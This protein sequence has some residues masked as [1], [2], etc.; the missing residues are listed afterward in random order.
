MPSTTTRL[1]AWGLLTMVLLAM[2]TLSACSSSPPEPSSTPQPTEAPEEGQT[3]TLITPDA[4]N[5]DNENTPKYQIQTRLT[6]FQLLSESEGI[7]WGVTKNELRLY[8]TRD[9]GKTW[10]NISPATTMQFLSNPVYGREIF[11]TDLNNGWIIRSSVGNL[12][13]IVL[14]T[15]DRGETWKVSAL[16]DQNSISS[17][18]FDSPARGWLLT[19]W[20]S[21]LNKQSKALHATTDGGATWELVMQNEQ[22]NPT[23]PNPVIPLEGVTTGMIFKD[24]MHGFVTLQ[25]GAL[26]KI[27]KTNDG[28]VSWEPGPAFTVN[29]RYAGCDRVLTG[30]PE[31][32]RSGKGMGWMP[33]GCQKEKENSIT[34]HGY[35][36]A[37]GGQNWKFT[38]FNFG[39]RTGINRHITP[40]F[41]DAQ[42]G[43]VLEGNTLY[44]TH[45]QG[46]TWEALPAS[47][48]LQSK[49][50]EY[51]EIV[52][53]QFFSA[54]VGWLLI[55]KKENRRSILL[56]TTNGG[57]SWRVM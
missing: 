27:Y 32:F 46:L 38:T 26:P 17:I 18:Y 30:K 55:E 21:T 24:N 3:I 54:E 36:T 41:L 42:T 11:F 35:F 45:N 12:E 49:L 51:P 53:I 57:V 39:A 16:S 44:Q 25:T 33:V 10:V 50:L 31:F 40:T 4:Q 29:E 9:N 28:G 8:M 20:D 15:K 48:V 37:N 43:W 5:L 19:A 13:T 47:S 56:Q 52:K 34:Y 23:I 7:A 2:L 14:R 6:D 22:Y 1:R